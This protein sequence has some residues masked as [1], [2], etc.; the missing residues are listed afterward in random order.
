LPSVPYRAPPNVQRLLHPLH[1]LLLAFPIALFGT[2]L[3]S[4]I[5]Y[6]NTAE[7]QWSNFSAWL[8]F[9]ALVF[10]APVLLWALIILLRDRRRNAHRHLAFYFLL[11]VGMWLAGLVNAFQHSRDGWSS[12][13]MFGL[14][15]SVISTVLGFMA[16]WTGHAGYREVAR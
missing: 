9:G 12:V 11:L 2:A 4:D 7:M 3:L 10:G 1:A 13:G 6:L 15:L 8:I 5:T 14:V 16:G